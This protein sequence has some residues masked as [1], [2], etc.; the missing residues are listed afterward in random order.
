MTESGRIAEDASPVVPWTMPSRT[1]VDITVDPGL[2]SRLVARLVT[3]AHDDPSYDFTHVRRQIPLR[4]DGTLDLELVREWTQGSH[5]TVIVTEIPRRAGHRPKISA[6]HVAEGL[7]VISL[8]ALGWLGLS[9]R[10]RA[11]VF[12]SLEALTH[13]DGTAPEVDFGQV[14]EQE[15]P[16]GPSYYVAAPR[17]GTL[18]LLLGMVRTNEPMRTA[19]R[20]SGALAAASA[21]GAFGIFYSSI[22]SMADALS[23]WRLTLITVLAILV[24]VPW[25]VLSNHLWE[26]RRRMGSLTEAT[27]YNAS[28]L[29]TLVVVVSLLYAALFV[30]ILVAA[31]VVIDPG[32]MASTIGER[33]TVANYVDI[34]WLSAS[35]GT[36]AGALGSNFDG[37]DD[38]RDLTHGRRQMMRYRARQDDEHGTHE[39]G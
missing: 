29:L 22:W 14:H 25:L 12:G 23:P 10:L 39:L 19:P 36:V 4:D 17:A 35:M 37:D 3:E 1:A 2:P 11:A 30:G 21:T 38:V 20:L 31:L 5:L 8:P 26:P 32:F 7:V 13:Y 28:T 9:D 33:A 16:T 34:A 24:M 18:R 6:L 27:M 15:S